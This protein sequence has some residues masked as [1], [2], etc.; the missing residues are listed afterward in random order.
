MPHPDVLMYNGQL[1][2][3]VI[4]EIYMVLLVNIVDSQMNLKNVR[5][6]YGRVRAAIKW[7]CRIVK[8]FGDD[9]A[10]FWSFLQHVGCVTDN[11]D[12]KYRQELPY[13]VW[14]GDKPRFRVYG[15]VCAYVTG[16]FPQEALQHFKRIQLVAWN[17]G[18]GKN[19]V[20]D[21][22]TVRDIH[23][24]TSKNDKIYRFL[25]LYQRPVARAVAAEFVNPAAT[26]GVCDVGED[27]KHKL[28]ILKRMYTL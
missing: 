12:E 15:R 7:I 1:L 2:P 9:H 11:A 27:L 20:I 21:C 3:M 16:D 19:V 13:P 4:V 26:A 6:V 17:A 25:K 22:T 10:S 18:V 14:L 23:W 24:R 28:A 8:V 5:D